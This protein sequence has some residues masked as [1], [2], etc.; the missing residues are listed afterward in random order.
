MSAQYN[1]T[2]IILYY[3]TNGWFKHNKN[4]IIDLITLKLFR[5]K[6]VGKLYWWVDT[7]IK[8]YLKKNYLMKYLTFYIRLSGQ[9]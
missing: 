4:I 9:K 2:N 8:Y 7:N 3:C 5:C 6:I 1:E